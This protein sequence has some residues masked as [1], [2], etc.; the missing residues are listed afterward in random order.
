MERPSN[1]AAQGGVDGVAIE[2]V[3]VTKRYGEI[4][5]L[6]SVSFDAQRGEMVACIGPNGAGK[7]TLL[8]MLAG[9]LEP[10]SG[11]IERGSRRV[12]WVP[13]RPAVYR[14]LSVSENLRLFARLE[15]VPSV[16]GA[17]ERM[18]EHTELHDRSGDPVEKLSGG[19]LH[20]VNI[21]IGL[22]ARPEVALLDEPT[23]A[24]DP[25]QREKTWDF[26]LNLAGSGTTIVF[27]SHNIEEVER[28]AHKVIVL[29]DGE[30]LFVGPPKQLLDLVVEESSGRHDDYPNL[31]AAFMEFLR[32]RGH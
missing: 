24:L 9:I 15:G 28:Y 1:G 17:V 16:Q 27:A 20:R 31:E 22:L 32:S 3:D 14:K 2:A 29:A 12:G 21:A 7:T 5:A 13:Q 8:S 6:R 4:W 10:D 25:R 11:T 18:L 23:A 30:G 19:N 26:I